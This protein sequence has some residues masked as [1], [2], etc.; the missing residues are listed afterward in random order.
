VALKHFERVLR[1]R[2]RH[3]R[4]AHNLTQEQAADK[5]GMSLKRYQNLELGI[6]FNPTL[7]TFYSL[8]KALNIL[9][10]EMA[11][12]FREPTKEELEHSKKIINRRA[13]KALAFQSTA[14]PKAKK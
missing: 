5:A 14:E 2:L 1:W 7:K 8:C 9:N 6:R 3:H 4:L 13:P 11:E 12:L 10:I